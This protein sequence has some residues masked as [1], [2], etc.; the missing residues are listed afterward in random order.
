MFLF[1]KRIEVSAGKV[2]KTHKTQHL[3]LQALLKTKKVKEIVIF[4]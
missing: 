1:S 4:K 3:P 2:K